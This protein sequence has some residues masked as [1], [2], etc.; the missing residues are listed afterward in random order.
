[1]PPAEFV[2]EWLANIEVTGM[3][4]L[5]HWVLSQPGSIA[6]AQGIAILDAAAVLAGQPE[7]GCDHEMPDEPVV[8]ESSSSP[9]VFVGQVASL[10]SMDLDAIVSLQPLLNGVPPVDLGDRLY[11]IKNPETV[12]LDEAVLW[13]LLEAVTDRMNRRCAPGADLSTAWAAGSEFISA[14][15]RLA[16]AA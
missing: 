12:D 1:M 6:W 2:S 4:R 10:R 14:R 8:A 7:E 5:Q 15:R 9:L 13:A 3:A 16:S 11:C